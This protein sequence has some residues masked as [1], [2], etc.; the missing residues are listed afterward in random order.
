M[1]TPIPGSNG[2][3]RKI[4][5]TCGVISSVLYVATD[6]LAV[7]RYTGYSYADQ[8]YSELLATGAPT[9]PLMLDGECRL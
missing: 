3:V 8:N 5:L 6:I 9:R 1:K 4:L 2:M 7:V